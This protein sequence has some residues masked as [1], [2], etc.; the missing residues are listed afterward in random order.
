MFYFNL[1]SYKNETLIFKKEQYTWIEICKNINFLP[2]KTNSCI[3]LI[4]KNIKTTV[5]YHKRF[6]ALIIKNFG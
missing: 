2:E 1:Y 4:L 6:L 5:Y 3:R